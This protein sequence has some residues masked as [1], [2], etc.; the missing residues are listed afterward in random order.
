MGNNYLQNSLSSNASGMIMPETNFTGYKFNDKIG[1]SIGNKYLNNTNNAGLG[2][3]SGGS[4]LAHKYGTRDFHFFVGF[5][6]T[7]FE[8]AFKLENCDNYFRPLFL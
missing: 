7:L 4:L 3:G 2:L 6:I 1:A 8:W 5:W